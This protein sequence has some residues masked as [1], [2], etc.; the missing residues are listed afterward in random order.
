MHNT[1]NMLD[2]TELFTLEW[3]ILCYATFTSIKKKKKETEL[4]GC[5]R[6]IVLETLIILL[7]STPSPS[8][9]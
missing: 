3:L 7:V 2:A 1:V 6:L 4:G 5:G 8:A 9:L